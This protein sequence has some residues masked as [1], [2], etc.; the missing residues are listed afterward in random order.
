MSLLD[1]KQNELNEGD[2]VVLM[3]QP[4]I[5]FT[6]VKIETPSI[7]TAQNANQPPTIQVLLEVQIPLATRV[8]RPMIPVM[9]VADPPAPSGRS[10]AFDSRTGAGGQA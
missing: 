10:A 4:T 2:Q 3:N 9:K 6:I 5:P 8:D 7:I 1:I